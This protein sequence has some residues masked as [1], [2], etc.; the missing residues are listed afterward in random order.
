[1]FHFSCIL[2][3]MKLAIYKDSGLQVLRKKKDEG[4]MFDRN[5]LSLNRQS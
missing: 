2:R 1:M 4:E 3:G 5:W